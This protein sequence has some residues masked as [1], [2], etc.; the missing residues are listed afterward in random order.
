MSRENRI[1][2]NDPAYDDPICAEIRQFRKEFS[3]RFNHDM[4]AM[5]RYFQERE[6]R[7]PPELLVSLAPRRVGSESSEAE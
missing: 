2:V 5:A 3:E 1:D 6:R 4:D 7:H